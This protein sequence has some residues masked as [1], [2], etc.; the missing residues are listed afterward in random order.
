MIS[1]F[2]NGELEFPSYASLDEAG[3]LVIEQ[4]NAEFYNMKA[5]MG[6]EELGIL[7][8]TGSVMVYEDNKVKSFFE[9][10]IAWIKARFEDIKKFFEAALKKFKAMVEKFKKKLVKSKIDALKNKVKYLKPKSYGKTYDYSGYMDI[11]KKAGPVWGA[12][13]KYDEDL[14]KVVG[15]L[16]NGIGYALVP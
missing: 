5:S 2:G 14:I 13:N 15:T 1:S 4:S 6:L 3:M 10:I 12:V 16:Y 7:E 8:S 9:K 11:L